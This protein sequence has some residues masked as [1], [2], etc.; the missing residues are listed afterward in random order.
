MGEISR[1]KASGQRDVLQQA[2]RRTLNR[3]RERARA[4]GLEGVWMQKLGGDPLKKTGAELELLTDI[5]MDLFVR[6]GNRGGISMVSKRY[7]KANN[8]LVLDY[9][10]GKPNSYITYLDAIL[11]LRLGNEQATPDKGF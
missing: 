3:G 6:T 9:D 1:H 5:G 11:S 8:S 10:P 4:E 2:E 7:G